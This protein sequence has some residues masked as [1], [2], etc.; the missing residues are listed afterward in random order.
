MKL[1]M[2]IKTRNRK[3]DDPGMWKY[4]IWNL[5]ILFP[6][7]AHFDR[8]RLRPELGFKL[9]CF[10]TAQAYMLCINCQ[11]LLLL[12]GT[13]SMVTNKVS[14]AFRYYGEIKSGTTFTIKTELD[15]FSTTKY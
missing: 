3:F 12:K 7:S 9:E 8:I 13:I 2:I 5:D 14:S 15:Q 11:H 6:S 1:K 4:W 10:A